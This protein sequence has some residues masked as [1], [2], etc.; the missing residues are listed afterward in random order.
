MARDECPQNQQENSTSENSHGIFVSSLSLNASRYLPPDGRGSHHCRF[1][2][3]APNPHLSTEVLELGFSVLP[4]KLGLV[5]YREPVHLVKST[6]N[7]VPKNCNE[8]CFSTRRQV[9]R[10]DL[11]GKKL[12]EI[13]PSSFFQIPPGSEANELVLVVVLVFSVGRTEITCGVSVINIERLPF[14]S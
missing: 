10:Y 12:A 6:G 14:A 1:Y 4:Q 3:L 9:I 8:E 5:G 13:I 7:F 2:D 11:A